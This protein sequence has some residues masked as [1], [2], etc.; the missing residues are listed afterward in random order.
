MRLRASSVSAKVPTY[1]YTVQFNKILA[2]SKKWILTWKL[3]RYKFQLNLYLHKEFEVNI[4]L[5]RVWS[6]YLTYENP[7]LQKDT[8]DN[9][10][11]HENFFIC[12]KKLVIPQWNEWFIF[13]EFR[14]PNGTSFVFISIDF[15]NN[16]ALQAFMVDHLSNVFYFPITVVYR[17]QNDQVRNRARDCFVVVITVC[18]M[19]GV[20]HLLWILQVQNDIDLSARDGEEMLCVGNRFLYD[21][22]RN[23]AW[24]KFEVV[25]LVCW[26]LG[27][28]QFLWM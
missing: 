6:Q 26:M 21:H 16:L 18:W 23:M 27:V 20:E 11:R 2:Q 17:F 25:L 10:S 4:W 14:F 28:E 3:L 1:N 15:N 13:G 12:V 8:W 7:L 5:M 19:F 9:V 22:A 24:D